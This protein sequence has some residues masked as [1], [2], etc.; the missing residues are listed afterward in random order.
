V[1]PTASSSEW[2]Q[3]RNNTVTIGDQNRLTTGGKPD[4]LTQLI[5]ERFEAYGAHK[6]NVAARGYFVKREVTPGWPSASTAANCNR[7]ST[8]KE[9][10][11]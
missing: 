7:I 11:C 2:G 8:L 1:R 6:L 5:F 9:I 10:A 4:I 3:F